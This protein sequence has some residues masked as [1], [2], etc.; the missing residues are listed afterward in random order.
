MGAQVVTG[1]IRFQSKTGIF[2]VLKFENGQIDHKKNQH[3]V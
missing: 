2:R 3:I 1:I